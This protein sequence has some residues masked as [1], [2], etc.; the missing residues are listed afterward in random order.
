MRSRRFVLPAIIAGL[1]LLTGCAPQAAAPSASPT[2]TAAAP[3]ATPTP[4]PADA[5][6]SRV[7]VHS[8]TVDVV[9][10]DGSTI[11]SVRYFDP[12]TDMVAA[13]TKAFKAEPVVSADPGAIETP[14]GTRYT[15][16]GFA[17]V[18]RDIE[19]SD[20]YFPAINLY[21]ETADV[22]GVRIETVGG[23]AVGDDVET[24]AAAASDK[25]SRYTM[26]DGTHS[27]NIR[28]DR[29]DIPPVG[30][31]PEARSWGVVLLGEANGSVTR[32]VAPSGDF[33]V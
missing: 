18:D 15:W 31:K 10:E 5:V 32:I 22:N 13:L 7:V 11:A 24:V 23:F 19:Q 26:G 4:T 17:I 27:V 1:A 20:P 12:A 25:V 30:D 8:Q 28:V 29:F 33:G 9:A 6:A 21:A 3:S 14:P 2:K 16:G